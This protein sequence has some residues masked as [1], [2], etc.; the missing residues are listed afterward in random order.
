MSYC[1]WSAVSHVY[2][3][4]HVDGY[5]TC[6]GC[7]LSTEDPFRYQRRPDPAFYSRSAAIEHL[8]RHRQ[9]GH[10]VPAYAFEQLQAEINE[11]SD[12]AQLGKRRV[13]QYKAKKRRLV[14]WLRRPRSRR[15]SFSLKGWNHF[16]KWN[17]ITS[18]KKIT[19]YTGDPE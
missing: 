2:M 8:E 11:L 12:T 6:C 4:H 15:K 13:P 5:I 14:R 7:C 16:M 17:R 9:A 3:F 10:L 19:D 18:W 1:R